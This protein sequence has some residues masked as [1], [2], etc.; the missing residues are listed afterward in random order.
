[1]VYRE[2]SA[3]D[4]TSQRATLPPFST[5][6]LLSLDRITGGKALSPPHPV[7]CHPLLPHEKLSSTLSTH[8]IRNTAVETARADAFETN[9]S[10]LTAGLRGAVGWRLLGEIF[11][12]NRTERET[13]GW[14]LEGKYFG[15]FS[16]KPSSTF[17]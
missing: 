1:M 17:E 16:D 15:V 13:K 4:V 8:S 9:A 2:T 11:G 6:T 7:S 14:G 10:C 3:Q 5:A 12:E